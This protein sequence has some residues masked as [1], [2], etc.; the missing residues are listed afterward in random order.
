M[1]LLIEDESLR[2]RHHVFRDRTH[3]GRLLAEKLGDYRGTETLVLAI[4][5]GGVPV[6]AQMSRMLAAE[7]DIVVVRKLQIP[8]NP[9]AGFGAVAADGD[10]IFNE[11]LLTHLDLSEDA[12]NVQIEKAMAA[13]KR[14]ERLFRKGKPYPSLAG[15]TV[16][17]VD[18]G[19][20]SGYTM[21]AAIRFLRKR[22]PN[23]TIVAVPTGSEK[24][25]RKIMD[26][27]DELVCLNVRSGVSFAVAHAYKNW[28]DLTEEE[29]LTL[30]GEGGTAPAK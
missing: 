6:A 17:V 3:A 27:V 21:L 30:L 2:D 28:Y 19:L 13:V 9:E 10:V 5:S 23:R 26:E 20:A 4:P 25:I 24:T 16:I 12:V 15:R 14:R 8:F 22:S 11:E 29:V 18:D 1:G 7:M